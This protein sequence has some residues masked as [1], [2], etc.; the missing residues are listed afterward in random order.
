MNENLN[1]ISLIEI[2]KSNVFKWVIIIITSACMCACM[3]FT[4]F[5]VMGYYSDI[6]WGKILLFYGLNIFWMAFGFLLIKKVIVNGRL[7]PKMYLLGKLFIVLIEVVQFNYII[8]MIPSRDFWAYAIFFLLLATF[9][10]DIKVI[11]TTIFELA[12]SLVIACIIRENEILPVNDSIYVADIF[13]RIICV[14]LSFASICLL[15]VFISK[16]L[17][18]AKE[19]EMRENQ[20]KVLQTFNY[21]TE[22]SDVLNEIADGNLA[23]K[24]QYDYTGEFE[25][26]KRALDNISASL[27]NT[28]KQIHT[29]AD[30]VSQSAD[31]AS[32]ES[33]ALAQG[34]TQQESSIETLVE[35]VNLVAENIK[36]NAKNSEYANQRVDAVS[37]EALESD[38]RMNDMVAAMN[39]ISNC[40]RNIGKIIKTIEDISFQTNILALNAA[41]EA[42]NAGEA[43]KGFAVVAEEVGGL[44]AKSAEASQNTAVLIEN[45]IKAV[46]NGTAIA[47][48]TAKSLKSVVSNIAE[49]ADNIG[50]IS[51]ASADQAMAVDQIKQGMNQISAVV[52]STSETAEKSA[53]SSKDLNY[54][55]KTLEGLVQKFKL[56]MSSENNG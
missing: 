15:V 14:S 13:I 28:M 27:N 20:S 36:Q 56:K 47:D 16:F 46:E 40:S 8:Y 32:Y 1:E 33:Q 18:K 5:K 41:V 43:G 42:A 22:I 49:I 44:A 3:T 25:S 26:I 45:S 48:K 53:V 10:I 11:L 7:I 19:K 30:K 50:V 4:V 12:A 2:Y 9:F 23:F 52:N 39:E 29:A 21:I 37:R 31:N 54:Q 6:G 38:K 17:I 34:A 51:Q 55:A 35:T 24:L